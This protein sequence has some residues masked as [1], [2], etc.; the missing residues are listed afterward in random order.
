MAKMLVPALTLPVRGATELVATMPVPASPSGGH[1]GT[2]RCS[3]R[4]GRSRAPAAV[5][6]PARLAGELHGGQHAARVQR[7]AGR[8]SHP[9]EGGDLG[10]VVVAGGDVDGEHAAGVA[11]A[12]DLLPGQLPVDVAGQGGQVVESLTWSSPSRSPGTG[13][14]RST[15]AGCCNRTPHSAAR[16]RRR[17][18][19]C[20]RYGKG[21]AGPLGIEGQVAMH[22]RRD[23]EAPTVLSWHTVPE[24]NGGGKVAVAGLEPCQA[25]SSE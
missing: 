10:G 8:G 17:C 25:A 15:G 20:A 9:V 11:D 23:A 3:G 13:A 5:S 21:P 24:L 18:W 1:R 2:P 22:H 12:E 19:C 14:R 16:R 6:S 7:H 4:W